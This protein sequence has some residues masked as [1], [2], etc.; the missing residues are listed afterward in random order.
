MRALPLV[1]LLAPPAPAMAQTAQTFSLPAGCTAYLTVQSNDCQ[2]SHHFSCSNYA[3][4]VQGRIDLGEM[5]ATYI[6]TIDAE[7]QWINGF[8]PDNG[9]TETLEPGPVDPASFTTLLD[10]GTDTYD[11]F[12]RNDQSGLLHFVGTDSLSGNSVTIDG[13]R[14]EETNM[15]ITALAEDGTKLWHSVGH[16]YVSRDW[17]VFLSGLGETTLATETYKYD[18]SPVEFILPGEPGFLSPNPKFGCDSVESKAQG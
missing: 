16:E 1:F 4:G 5:G 15:D 18:G 2:V 13:I 11:F 14:L 7:A 12:T 17:R 3:P 8:H 10:S 6:G 9:S